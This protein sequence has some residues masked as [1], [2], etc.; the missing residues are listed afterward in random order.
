[1]FYDYLLLGKLL[2]I[3]CTA[4]MIK[5]YFPMRIEIK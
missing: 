2:V 5:Y 4:L 3:D 1:M